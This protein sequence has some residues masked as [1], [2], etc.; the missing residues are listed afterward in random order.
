[1]QEAE[2]E[3]A[4]VFVAL[5][6]AVAEAR[7]LR[8]NAHTAAEARR[9]VGADEASQIVA[10]ANSRLEA[11][12]S[13]AA[14]ASLMALDEQRGRLEADARAE[15]E[16][17]HFVADANLGEVVAHVVAGVWATGNELPAPVSH[18]S[19]GEVVG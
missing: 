4:P 8:E 12:R 6:S 1:V 13:E 3:L 15:A 16:R 9:R 7:Q 14:S 19:H 2:A 5:E 17:V 10:E 18:D 11:V